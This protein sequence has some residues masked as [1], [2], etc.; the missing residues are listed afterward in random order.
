MTSETPASEP[1]T[2]EPV[3]GKGY[4]RF[5]AITGGLFAV[6]AIAIP[7]VIIASSMTGSASGGSAAPPPTAAPDNPGESIAADTGCLACHTTDGTDSVGPTWLGLTGSERPL[8]SGDTVVA[9]DPYL[10]ESI[11]DPK[12][13]IVAGFDPLMPETYSDQ[14]SEQEIRDLVTY[15]NSLG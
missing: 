15:I 6:I 2:K 8:E 5:L 9:D 10:E 14:L 4:M 11:V 13:K 12:A 7:M 3:F 1:D